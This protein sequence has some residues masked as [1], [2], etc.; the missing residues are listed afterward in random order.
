MG[1]TR[2]C[3]TCASSARPKVCRSQGGVAARLQSQQ[4]VASGARTAG[5]QRRSESAFLRVLICLMC[6]SAKRRSRSASLN[7]CSHG[8]HRRT[9]HPA[10]CRTSCAAA[11]RPTASVN[12]YGDPWRGQGNC[13][14]GARLL[15]LLR[16]PLA[17]VL[18]RH[19]CPAQHARLR[20]EVP[21][22]MQPPP[23][24]PASR[25]NPRKQSKQRRGRTA[26]ARG[27]ARAPPQRSTARGRRAQRGTASARAAAR[28][29][30]ARGARC[31]AGAPRARAAATAA[32]G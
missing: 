1:C 12:F 18:Q 11:C 15:E 14:V 23:Q 24:H 5:S 26:A 19:L 7:T 6:H 2:S 8:R 9:H 21:A 22:H 31:R 3:C 28:A 30:R 16:E 29:A 32:R 13:R 10:A 17:L 25:Q 27:G 4:Q 20:L